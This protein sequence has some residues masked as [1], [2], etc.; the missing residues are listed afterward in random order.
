MTQQKLTW[1]T[2]VTGLALPIVRI[3]QSS[4]WLAIRWGWRIAKIGLHCAYGSRRTVWADTAPTA[5]RKL[6]EYF[7]ICRYSKMRDI[8]KKTITAQEVR[9]CKD[10]SRL[11]IHVLPPGCARNNSVPLVGHHRTTIAHSVIRNYT[12][13]I[14]GLGWLVGI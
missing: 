10:L 12:S 8:Y 2:S 9:P 6:S 1:A 14:C 5:K 4:T 11:S 13:C 7:I 3:V